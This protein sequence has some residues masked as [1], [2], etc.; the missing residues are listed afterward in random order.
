[1][2][3]QYQAQIAFEDCTP[4]LPVIEAP[5][6]VPGEQF[7]WRGMLWTKGYSANNALR[8]AESGQYLLIQQNPHKGGSE[9]APLC[10]PGHPPHVLPT[11]QVC[12][13]LAPHSIWWVIDRTRNRG[14][15][16]VYQIIDG[17]GRSL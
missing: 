9:W 7:I 3:T 13:G 16:F 1:M 11:G 5:I 10:W 8:S 12:N 4:L 6:H 14:S 15:G 2:S 17:I